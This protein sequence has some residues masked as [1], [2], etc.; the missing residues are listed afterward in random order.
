MLITS[1]SLCEY[2]SFLDT[3]KY[4]PKAV[5]NLPVLGCVQKPNNLLILQK[6]YIYIV[7]I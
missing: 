2:P 1:Y 4:A 7:K 6:K 3:E 5:P